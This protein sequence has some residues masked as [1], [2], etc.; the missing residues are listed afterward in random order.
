MHADAIHYWDWPFGVSN[1]SQTQLFKKS[2]F[3]SIESVD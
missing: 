3:E 1:V 2:V